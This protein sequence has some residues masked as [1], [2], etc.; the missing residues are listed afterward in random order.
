MRFQKNTFVEDLSKTF[1]LS[2]EVLG[3][4]INYILCTPGLNI[5]FW[6]IMIQILVALVLTD[7]SSTNTFNHF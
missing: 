5:L 6:V 1:F 3:Q 2:L 4:Q 7:L